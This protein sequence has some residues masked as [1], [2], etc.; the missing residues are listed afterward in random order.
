[1][2]IKTKTMLAAEYGVCR[3]TLRKW[4]GAMPYEFPRILTEPW[5][6]LIYEELGYPKM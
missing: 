5:L 2:L 6:K 3:K 1:M 4:M